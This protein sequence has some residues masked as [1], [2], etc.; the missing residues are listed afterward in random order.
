[1]S[2]PIV[3]CGCYSNTHRQKWDVSTEMS[4]NKQAREIAKCVTEL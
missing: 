2:T 3:L 1:M 4:Q